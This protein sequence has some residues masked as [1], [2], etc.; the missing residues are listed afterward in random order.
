M[1]GKTATTTQSVQIPPEVMARYRAVNTRAEQVAEQPF[2]QYGGQFVAP[3]TGTQQAGV[4]AIQQ[5]SGAAQ[6]YYGAA[7]GLTAGAA[8]DVSPGALETQKYLS[9]YTENVVDATRRALEQQQGMQ[10]SEQ[11]SAAIRGGAFGGDRAAIQRAVLQGQQGLA[12]AQAVAPLYQQGFG[13]ALQTAQQQQGVNLA[14]EQ[15]NKQRQLAAGAQ[16]GQLGTGAQGAGLA[17]A[18]ALLGAG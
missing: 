10:L 13:Q 2:Q 7:A 9:P 14:A 6:P 17:G 16:F 5:A 15:A 18:Q 1:G 11:Q 3:L 4:Q 12:T 8:G